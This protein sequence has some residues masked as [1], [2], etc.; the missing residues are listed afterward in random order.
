LLSITP[1]SGNNLIPTPVVITGTNFLGSPSLK[2]GDTWLESVT[3]VDANTIT[4]TVPAGIPEGVYDLTLYNGD[5]QSS[6]LSD[7]FTV[8][9][10]DIPIT[11]LVATNDGPT[12][13]G[14]LTTFS[15]TIETGTNVTYTWEFGDGGTGSGQE[16]SYVYA[17]T[18]VYTA[19]VT[20]TNSYGSAE[21]PTEVN[22][23]TP[24]QEYN[25]VYMPVSFR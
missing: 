22:I 13:L 12:E 1:N 7:T 24:P 14:S 19:T 3:L 5:C 15:A 10:E 20:A 11:G 17:D 6:V 9:V 4:A 18:G 23:I 16:T 2:L 25:F 21:A 8:Y